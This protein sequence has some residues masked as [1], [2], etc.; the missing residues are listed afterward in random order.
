MRIKIGVPV[1][2]QHADF[3]GMRRAWREPEELVQWR[4]ARGG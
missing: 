3:D 2:P 1:Q 4:D